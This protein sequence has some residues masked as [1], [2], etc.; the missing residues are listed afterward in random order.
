M[1]FVFFLDEIT[2]V[3]LSNSVGA[4]SGFSDSMINGNCYVIN[5]L[6]LPVKTSNP[7][8]PIY[9]SS[10]EFYVSKPGQINFGVITFYTV[11]LILVLKKK[12]F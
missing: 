10:F 3:I 12:Y 4:V 7:K 5:N 2:P 11:I 8:D 1:L 9:L 6:A